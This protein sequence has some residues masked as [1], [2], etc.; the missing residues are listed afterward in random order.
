MHAPPS[1]TMPPIWL[2]HAN[3]LS[4]C[5]PS[6]LSLDPSLSSAALTLRKPKRAVPAAMAAQLRYY[7]HDMHAAAFKLPVMADS[8]LGSVRPR[9][10]GPSFLETLALPI[11]AAAVLTAALVVFTTRR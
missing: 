9:D 10:S 6:K 1:P 2:S 5:A 8:K 3:A 11:A 7:S 4:P